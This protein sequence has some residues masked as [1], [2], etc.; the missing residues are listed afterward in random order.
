MY[1]SYSSV[2]Q[3]RTIRLL[4]TITVSQD[5]QMITGDISN[6]FVQAPTCKNIWTRAGKEFGERENCVIILDKAL[7]G[8]STSA[9]QWNITLG[10]EI[11]KYG[12]HTM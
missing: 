12:I 4:Q 11:K 6:A 7:Y 9:R 3:T 8:L 10:A 5:L 1:E 2:I